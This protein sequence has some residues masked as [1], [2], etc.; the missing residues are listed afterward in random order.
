MAAPGMREGTRGPDGAFCE[1][2]REN[3]FTVIVAIILGWMEQRY[4]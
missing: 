1:G 3:Y 2:A 4:L